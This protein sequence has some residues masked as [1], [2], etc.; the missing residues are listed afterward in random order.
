V[1]VEQSPVKKTVATH[2]PTLI[3][4]LLFLGCLSTSSVHAQATSASGPA[5]VTG[6]SQSYT[7]NPCQGNVPPAPTN[8]PA[9]VW[10]SGTVTVLVDG[11]SASASYGGPSQ[12]SAQIASLLQTA[13][14]ASNSP[15]T[16]SLSGSVIT[17]TAKTAGMSSDY[18][19]TTSS[20]Y[21]TQYFSTSAFN[22]SCSTLTGGRSVPTITW[23][24][25]AAISYG[26]TLSATQLDATA[27]IGGS[28]SYSPAAG[29][30]PATGTDT[31]TVTFSPTD[32]TDYTNATGSVSLTVNKATPTITWATPAAIAYPTALSATQLNATAS[33][34]GT[35]AYSPA[36]GTTPL[37]GSDTL[38]VTFT[39]TDTT[40]YNTATKSVSLTVNKATPTITWS[41]PTAITYGTALSSTQ[42]NAT[43]ST[44]GTFSYSPAS[45]STP[46]AGTDTLSV[47]FTPTD[48]TDY[49]SATKSVNLTVNKANP[50]VTWLT[51][52]AITYGTAL[53]ATQLNAT[54]SVGGSFAYTPASG[55]TPLAGT[56]TLSVTFTPT[57]TTDYNTA[58]K[59][60]SL[61]VNKA[62][63]TIT[64]STPAAISYGTA[65]SSTQ[66]NATASAGGTF[67]YSPASGTTPLAGTDTL[68]V[69][70]TPT[71][72]SDYNSATKSV[73]LTVNK[74]TPT[75]TWPTPAS[76]SYGTALSSTQ[77][78]ATASVGGT[79]VY[80]PAA[81]TVP[82]KGADTLSVTFTPSDTSDYTTATAT[83]SVSV[84]QT[85]PTITWPAPAAITYGTALSASQL[86]ATAS[87]GGTF[88]YSPA[89]GTIPAGGTD[90]LSVTFTPTDTTD[91]TTATKSVS[92]TV[93]K[94]TPAISFVIG[95]DSIAYGQ[96]TTVTVQVSCNSACGSVAYQ[97]DS[98]SWQTDTLTSSGGYTAT[99][100]NTWAIG[101]HTIQVNYLG[102]GN[103][104]AASSTGQTLTI[105]VASPGVTW[106]APAAITYGTLLSATQLDASASIPGTF[107]Y[108][109][110]TGTRLPPGT[111]TLSVTF[112]P[113]NTTD[114]EVVTQ[115][116]SIAV[117]EPTLVPNSPVYSY[118]AI[119]DPVGKVLSYNDSVMGIWNFSYDN[120]NRLTSG[121]PV[122]G[123]P[124]QDANQNL[125]FRH[126][127][128]GNRTV[129]T[130]QT[131]SCTSA[132]PTASYNAANQIATSAMSAVYTYDSTGDILFDGQNYYS[133]DAE[134]RLCAVQ[135]YPVSGGAVATVYIYDA[136]G[137]RV[138]KESVPPSSNPVSQPLSC[139]PSQSGK[140]LT[141]N[142]VLGQSGSQLTTTDGNGNWQRTN[143]YGGSEQLAT[144]D[145]GGLH[146]HLS[147]S[148]GT[149][150]VQTDWQGWPEEQ[151]QSLPYGDQLNCADVAIP[152]PTADD[153]NALHFTGKERDAESGNDYFGARYYASTMG[154]FLS[155]DWSKNPQGVP[156]A[157]FTNPQ[158]LNL[159]GYVLNNPLSHA[160]PDGHECDAC[161][162]FYQALTD[163]ISVKVSTT[164]GTHDEGSFLGLKVGISSGSS[165]SVTYHPFSDKEPEISSENKSTIEAKIG[166]GKVEADIPMQTPTTPDGKPTVSAGSDKPSVKV[167]SDGEISLAGVTATVEGKGPGGGV[168]VD[169]NSKDL[170]TAA[171]TFFPAVVGGAKE[172]INGA[173]NINPPA[174]APQRQIF[175]P[176]QQQ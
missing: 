140:V 73:T 56:D 95:N 142:Y 172:I 40:D 26:T 81:G 100:V 171:K 88:A 4:V 16:A 13:L 82:S 31:L 109:P 22:A 141:E 146:F 107:V 61:S 157:D 149:R 69:T 89:S 126:D 139:N 19:C 85:T 143:V 46:L 10:N 154:R 87:V 63:P 144:Y 68:S 170:V 176:N 116:V 50:T 18:S 20:T 71:D 90:T 152:A 148:L 120:F 168:E 173:M 6:S 94:A 156:Y 108:T 128:F 53:S 163:M 135:S 58:T 47:T 118:S 166:P 45:G 167:S 57:D 7:Y 117:N 36:S 92:L 164:A 80:S 101:P 1:A 129:E 35:L 174:P 23:S 24:T 55:T 42:L 66:L 123:A 124:S 121:V 62:T 39:P 54:A 76:I 138:A 44:G 97:L 150:R 93:N 103:Y 25:P 14:S 11:F 37:A 151:C 105:N 119:Y 98:G 132:I 77:L 51:P 104:N 79:F 131:E 110:A 153:A 48:T 8:C 60:V 83:V 161:K 165:V 33:V 159:Y 32:T 78:N 175:P 115:T 28:F 49:N 136:E 99:T 64:W 17:L 75:I 137:R 127:A 160:D 86:N 43:S 29:T 147:D 134:G 72:T 122:S 74:A 9:T 15:V 38:S 27:S 34:G 145:L 2:T 21:N 111:S 5:T 169:A 102:N 155:P 41:T 162:Q 67:S 106:P 114:Y 125:C 52:A 133:Y 3:L 59:S 84:S 70:F 96:T 91:Y 112:T 113:T 12:T 30:S 158:S 65:L 130:Q